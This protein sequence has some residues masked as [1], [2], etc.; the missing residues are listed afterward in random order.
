MDKNDLSGWTL[1]LDR[2][3]VINERI[4]G[5]YVRKVEEFV[6][7]PKVLDA[8]SI[9]AQHFAT[10]VIVTNQQGITKGVM[11][12]EDLQS[13]HQAMKQAVSVAGGRFD[14]IYYCKEL[15]TSNPWCRKPN[16]GMAHQAKADF[17][18]IDFT[19]S[20]MVGD[21]ISDMEFGQ[22]LGMKTVYLPTKEEEHAAGKLLKVDMRVES[23]W[24]FVEKGLSFCSP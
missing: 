21:S 19:K 8:L 9:L 17:P 13:V 12:E 11:T 5:S 16:P 2:D 1:F 18:Q 6:F 3:G 10:I 20:I 22:R 24:E 7:L 4:P 15:A 23:L 14:E